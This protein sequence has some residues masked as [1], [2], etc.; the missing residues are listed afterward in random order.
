[1]SAR[2]FG[3]SS[4]RKALTLLATDMAKKQKQKKKSK[5]LLINSL[6]KLMLKEI[7]LLPTHQALDP[8]E[9][10]HLL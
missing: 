1:M 7:K 2:V 9:V 8:T 4:P 6:E 10:T 5:L 3:L